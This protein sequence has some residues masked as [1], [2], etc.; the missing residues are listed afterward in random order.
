MSRTVINVFDGRPCCRKKVKPHKRFVFRWATGIQS[1][2]E[3]KMARLTNEEQVSVTVAPKT[4][5]GRPATIDGNVAWASSDEAVCTVAS[6]GPLT[7]LVVAV[8]PG[9]AQ[10]TAVFDADL[11]VGETREIT[12]SGAVEVVAAEAAT[13]E[14]VFGTPELTPLP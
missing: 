7:G 2:V 5:A 11:D 1:F 4:A 14:I 12:M 13:G 9:V 8:G 3:G 6:T 10:V